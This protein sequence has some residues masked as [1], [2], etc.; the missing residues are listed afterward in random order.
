MYF[1][2]ILNV[3]SYFDFLSRDTRKIREESNLTIRLV[4]H[5]ARMRDC[6]ENLDPVSTVPREQFVKSDSSTEITQIPARTFKS[7]V[8]YT[9]IRPR[10][11]LMGAKSSPRDDCLQLFPEIYLITCASRNCTSEKYP[12]YRSGRVLVPGL[13]LQLLLIRDQ[14]DCY[15]KFYLLSL[16]NHSFIQVVY[17]EFYVD[18]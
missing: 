11:A 7:C 8:R 12:G 14:V 3:A 17:K 10:A 6:H 18:V 2:C 15:H 16:L 13:D 1:V 9:R 5:S 4:C